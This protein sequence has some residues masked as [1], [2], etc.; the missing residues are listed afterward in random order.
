MRKSQQEQDVAASREDA[1]RANSA[2]EA[3]QAA[4]DAQSV[5]LASLRQTSAAAISHLKLTNETQAQTL[6]TLK[7]KHD[8][9]T[10]KEEV[11]V[12]HK[13]QLAELK[14]LNQTQ[15]RKLAEVT[16]TKDA[17]M[18][19]IEALRNENAAL[20]QQ[21]GEAQARFHHLQFKVA[22]RRSWSFVVNVQATPKTRER[23][24]ATL[25][26]QRA[27]LITGSDISKKGQKLE[28]ISMGSIYPTFSEQVRGLEMRSRSDACK[29]LADLWLA[30]TQSKH[31]I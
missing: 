11:K 28:C 23:A 6:R 21:L 18:A 19:S 9:A 22:Q 14:E 5:E 27:R 25:S 29:T 2:R 17:Q 13:A 24:R 31:R 15:S 20:A 3:L 4:Y 30:T 7:S 1:R 26:Y 10:S 12:Q 16:Q 8:S